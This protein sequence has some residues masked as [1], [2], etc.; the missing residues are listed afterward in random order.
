[1]GKVA[2]ADAVLLE[3]RAKRIRAILADL[4]VYD[5]GSAALAVA[6]EKAIAAGIRPERFGYMAETLMHA[7]LLKG[8][9]GEA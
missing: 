2:V 5:A 6:A 1:M 3:E 7:L 4:D 9:G 8:R